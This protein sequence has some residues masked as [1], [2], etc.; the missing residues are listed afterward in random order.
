MRLA[1]LKCSGQSVQTNHLHWLKSHEIV[2]MRQIHN[3]H[4][5]NCPSE[6]CIC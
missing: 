3:W 2:N 6:E 1:Y 4:A 5:K